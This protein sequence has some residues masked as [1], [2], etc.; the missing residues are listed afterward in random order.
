MSDYSYHCKKCGFYASDNDKEKIK[1]IS[2]KHRQH[3]CPL[4]STFSGSRARPEAAKH[5]ND[6]AGAIE[7]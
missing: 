6:E 7:I 1:K 3:P 4:K 2:K 5:I